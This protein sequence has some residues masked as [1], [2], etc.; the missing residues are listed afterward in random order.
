MTAHR[1]YRARMFKHCVTASYRDFESMLKAICDSEG[2]EYAKGD[3]ASELITK[4]TDKG[5]FTHAF[6]K[7]FTA[8]VAMLKTGLP[9]G[10]ETMPMASLAAASVTA[11]IARLGMNLTAIQH[12]RSLGNSHTVKKGEASQTTQHG[13]R[14][15]RDTMRRRRRRVARR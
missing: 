6:D 14:Q 7:S 5:L 9:T 12:A 2:W 1:H 8:Y 3:R 4:V 10:D 15:E 13:G 11:E